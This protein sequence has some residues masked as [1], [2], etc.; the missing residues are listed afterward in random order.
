MIKEF[1]IKAGESV[2]TFTP[3]Y[4][5]TSIRGEMEYWRMTEET[6]L[7][8]GTGILRHKF[9]GYTKMRPTRRNVLN[10]F[11]TVHETEKRILANDGWKDFCYC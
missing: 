4:P 3:L 6:P 2:F 11:F 5:V 7:P 1:S 10:Q 8:D 9:H